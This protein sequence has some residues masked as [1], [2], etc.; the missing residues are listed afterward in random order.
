MKNPEIDNECL[1]KLAK[2]MDK[3]IDE[4]KQDNDRLKDE[5]GDIFARYMAFNRCHS[6]C[7]IFRPLRD[8]IRSSTMS[9]YLL[10][11]KIFHTEIAKKN[12]WHQHDLTEHSFFVNKKDN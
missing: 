8:V 2:W 1:L 11:D 4:L 10:Q 7:Q 5:K 6:I 3:L 9:G 12:D